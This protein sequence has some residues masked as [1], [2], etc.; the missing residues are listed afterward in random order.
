M[1]RK[2]K[3]LD[4]LELAVGERIKMINCI[5]E[6][7]REKILEEKLWNSLL[8]M[9]NVTLNGKQ[10]FQETNQLTGFCLEKQP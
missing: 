3:K 2:Q 6:K 5:K 9:E 4:L 8:E 7:L 10:I 1:N